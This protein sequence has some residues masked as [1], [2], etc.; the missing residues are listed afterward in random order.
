MLKNQP[1]LLGM[2]MLNKQL[3]NVMN[4]YVQ[5]LNKF[6]AKLNFID[7]IPVFEKNKKKNKNS[8]TKRE[9]SSY[10]A[11][12]DLPSGQEPGDRWS[13]SQGD[14]N[15]NR[16]ESLVAEHGQGQ[17][18]A[19]RRRKL[20]RPIRIRRLDFAGFGSV[21]RRVTDVG[22]FLEDGLDVDVALD[23]NVE[24]GNGGAGDGEVDPGGDLAVLLHEL[25]E[26]TAA[27]EERH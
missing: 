5:I 6:N 25:T 11:L 2:K 15:P 24:A 14:R 10:T 7:R 23:G 18:T 8:Q 22:N 27:A 4:K 26:S 21:F 16:E 13:Q 1:Q 9:G 20:R 12:D 19:T 17:S 3:T